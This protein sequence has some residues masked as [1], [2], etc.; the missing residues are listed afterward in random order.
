VG[1][2]LSIVLAATLLGKPTFAADKI[3][4]GYSGMTISNALLLRIA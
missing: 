2:L 4:I 1:V 3:R